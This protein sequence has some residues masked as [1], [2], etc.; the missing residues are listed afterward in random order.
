MTPVVIMVILFGAFQF[1]EAENLNCYFVDFQYWYK[2]Y[3]CRVTSFDNSDDNR[4]ITER[5]GKHLPNKEDR[6]VK[7]IFI[8][9]TTVK[10]IPENIGLLFDLHAFAI[11]DCGLVQIRSKDFYG[12]N[13]VEHMDL[14]M[15]KLTVLPS[16]TFSALTK[17]ILIDLSYNQIEEL[18]N[19]LFCNNLKLVT[20]QLVQN[21][22]KFIGPTIFDR[23]TNLVEANFSENICVSKKYHYQSALDE[24]KKDIK[25]KCKK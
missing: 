7:M 17:L 21:K 9:K 18:P 4:I 20:V 3:T 2:F 1:G 16:N 22:I 10:F 23:T 13:H 5:A 14:G 6:D 15:N 12:M 11:R 25:I 24:L 19:S 8:G